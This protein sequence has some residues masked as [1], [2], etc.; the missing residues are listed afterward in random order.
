MQ[1]GI[2]SLLFSLFLLAPQSSHASNLPDSSAATIGPIKITVYG[3]GG[4]ISD[5]DNHKICSEVATAICGTIVMNEGSDKR[6]AQGTLSTA[7]GERYKISFIPQST[8][9]ED[10]LPGNKLQF[11]VLDKQ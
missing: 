3:K 5:G 2:L 1:R 11:Q 7:N 8:P 6:L 10:R 4:L 9:S